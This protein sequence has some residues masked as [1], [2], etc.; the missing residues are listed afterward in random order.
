MRSFRCSIARNNKE[1]SKLTVHSQSG[2]SA[3]LE[4]AELWDGGGKGDLRRG[5]DGGKAAKWRFTCKVACLLGLCLFSHGLLADDW[6]GCL[7]HRGLAHP[8]GI[9]G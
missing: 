6:V 7:P 8:Q 4:P 2:V 5:G 1:G 3:W 9:Q